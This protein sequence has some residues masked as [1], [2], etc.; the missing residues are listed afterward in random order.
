M[1]LIFS[2]LLVAGVG[3]YALIIEPNRL[4]VVEYNIESPK[5]SS[6]PLKIA[7]IAD[8]HA[9]WPWM[10]VKHLEHIVKKVNQQDA[11][12]ILLLGDLV[13]THPFGIP[14][15]PEKGITPYEVLKSKCGTYSVLGNHDLDGHEDSKWAKAI[16][17][18]NLN[19]LENAATKVKCNG[20]TFWI[21]GLEELWWQNKNIE[22]TLSQVTDNA[23]VIL[24]THNPD[25]FVNTPQSVA[26]TVA[27]HTHRG[28]IRLPFWGAVEAVIPSRYGKR[29]LYGHIIEDGKDL[30]VSGGLGTTGI[31]LRFL[32]PPEVVIINLSA[33]N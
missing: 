17:E 20:E 6:K 7:L 18:S 23:P 2:L 14:I 26:L 29:F 19:L 27:G 30:V 3:L 11:D 33:A 22:K 31:P 21:T 9:I 1:F 32:A 12:I 4:K 13:A 15:K 16:R 28:Q 24:M 25:A 5:W 10:S 8:T